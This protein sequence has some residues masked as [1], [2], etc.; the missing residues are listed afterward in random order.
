MKRNTMVF[1]K[2]FPINIHE[3]VLRIY[4][5]VI[6]HFEAI[7]VRILLGTTGLKQMHGE[8]LWRGSTRQSPNTTAVKRC[9]T[10]FVS[11]KWHGYYKQVIM[12]L[13]LKLHVWVK[14]PSVPAEK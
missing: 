11:F 7:K 3:F 2:K 14:Q 6:Y 9:R 1:V 4:H 12:Y 8:P 13:Q 10:T 5:Q